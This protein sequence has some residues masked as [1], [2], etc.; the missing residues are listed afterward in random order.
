MN[1]DGDVI[2]DFCKERETKVDSAWYADFNRKRITSS[3]GN[4]GGGGG[5]I[6][7]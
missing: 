2:S 3:S 5:E 6:G 1:P 7:N 4:K